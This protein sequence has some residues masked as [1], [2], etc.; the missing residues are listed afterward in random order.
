MP[1][2]FSILISDTVPKYTLL[3][4]GNLNEHC[5]YCQSKN[6]NF[7]ESCKTGV[8]K[9]RKYTYFSG[10]LAMLYDLTIIFGNQE[11]LYV[12]C[13][14]KKPCF[15]CLW[16]NSCWQQKLTYILKMLSSCLYF[17]RFM[18]HI[19]ISTAVLKEEARE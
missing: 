7:R 18:L 16:E 1:D 13:L 10:M 3:S 19:S 9:S 5:L 11:F 4:K 12:L 17:I 15:V 6:F 14:P 2:K 8:T